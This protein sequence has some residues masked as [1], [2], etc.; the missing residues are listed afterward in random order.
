MMLVFWSAYV[1]AVALTNSAWY[2]SVT[3][4]TLPTVLG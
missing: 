1:R 3:V 4:P 2:N